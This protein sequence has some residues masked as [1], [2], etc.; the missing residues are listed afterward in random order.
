VSVAYPL[1]RHGIDVVGRDVDDVPFLLGDHDGR[2][3]SSEEVCAVEVGANH[4]LEVAQSL[5][6]VLARPHA[7]GDARIVHEDVDA[8][9]TLH[10]A[11]DDPTFGVSHRSP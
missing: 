8:A 5:L 4:L 3:R 7:A 9:M 11:V 6:P 10:R 2:G 1:P